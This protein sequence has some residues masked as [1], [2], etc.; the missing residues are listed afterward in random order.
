MEKIITIGLDLAKSV[1]QVHAITEGGHVAARRALRR[2][3]V[4]EFFSSIEPC[5]RRYRA[6]PANSDSSLSGFS[7]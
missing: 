7:A 6:G 5:L 4:L 3:Q 2:S 1:F